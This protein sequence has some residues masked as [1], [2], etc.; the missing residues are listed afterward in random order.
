VSFIPNGVHQPNSAPRDYLSSIT[1][2]Q[3]AQRI[4]FVGRLSQEKRPDLFINMAKLVY[5]NYPNS[6]FVIIGSGPLEIEIRRLAYGLNVNSRISFLGLRRD[7]G[8]LLHGVDVLVCP[9]DTEGTPRVVVEAMASGVPVV[10]TCVG[11]LPDLVIDEVT[12]LLVPAGDVKALAG[13]V[14]RLLSDGTIARRISMAAA[15]EARARLSIGGME[16]KVASAYRQ[17]CITSTTVT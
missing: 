5:E 9:S 15:L 12:G 2:L 4:A 10:A 1:G 14:S 6:S 11:G 7:V 3:A 8:E 17:A 16:L 13:A